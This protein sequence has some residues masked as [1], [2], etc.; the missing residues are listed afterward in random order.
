M[1][2]TRLAAID[3]A[4]A[5]ARVQAEGWRSAYR[6]IVPDDYL[7]SIDIDSWADRQRSYPDKCWA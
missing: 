4:N 2:T 3:D 7:D 1:I 5:I 6:G